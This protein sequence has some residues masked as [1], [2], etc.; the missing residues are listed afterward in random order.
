MIYQTKEVALTEIRPNDHNPRF[1]KD[2]KFADL[3]RSIKAFP[4]MLKVRPIV[5]NQAMTILGGNM[6]LKACKEAGLTDVPVTIVDWSEEKQ[7]EFI[8]KDNLAF[9]E[10]DWQILAN[11]WEQEKLNDWGLETPDEWDK[12]EEEPP[13]ASADPRYVVGI[14]AMI[15]DFIEAHGLTAKMTKVELL[16]DDDTELY[17]VKM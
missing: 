14:K 3:V 13:L 1:I 16:G 7:R 5:V 11:E 8:I 15:E 4:E 9:G 17:M 12:E 6:R 10:W 2:E